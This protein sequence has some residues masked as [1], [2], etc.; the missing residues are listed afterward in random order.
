MIYL[1][2]TLKQVEDQMLNTDF[3][4][5]ADNESD[6]K[7]IMNILQSHCPLIYYR[8]MMAQIMKNFC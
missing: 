5:Q 1:V 6:I 7:T 2:Q 4:I 8:T 3:V